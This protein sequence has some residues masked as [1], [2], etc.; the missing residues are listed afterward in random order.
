MPN[1]SGTPRAVMIEGITFR[2]AG[3]AN[4]TLILS[5]F[6]NVMNPTSGTA[7]L[8]QTKRVP[9]AENVTLIT[10]ADDREQLVSFADSTDLLN[11]SITLRSGDTYSCRGKI[12]YENTETD[13][14][15][16]PIQMLTE[17]GWTLFG[18]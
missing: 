5:Q 8:Q 11:M 17:D 1:V 16:T 10:N 9:R 15:R 13:T 6:E 12:E 3:D 18:A 2:A 14:N 7:E 4:I